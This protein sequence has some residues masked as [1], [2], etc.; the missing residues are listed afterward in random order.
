MAY[1]FVVKL[2]P[3]EK[4]IK[5]GVQIASGRPTIHTNQSSSGSE[6]GS[7]SLYLL[8]IKITAHKPLALIHINSTHRVQAQMHARMAPAQWIY[9]SFF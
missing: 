8:M 2:M 4:N 7:P 3:R 9:G 6:L 5:L 1:L